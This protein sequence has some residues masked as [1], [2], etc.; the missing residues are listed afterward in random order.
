MP[1]RK[2]IKGKTPAVPQS[3]AL[4]QGP[5]EPIRSTPPAV[6]TGAAT[7]KD[8]DLQGQ[9]NALSVQFNRLLNQ[10]SQE[11]HSSPTSSP[12]IHEDL[13]DPLPISLT[14]LPSIP[15]IT[16]LQGREN[17]NIWVDEIQTTAEIYGIWDIIESAKPVA[18]TKQQQAFARSLLFTN[19][20][21]SIQSSLT[22]HRTAAAIWQHLD[23]QYNRLNIAQLVQHVQDLISIDYNSFDSIESFQQ[24]A[25]TLFQQIKEYSGSPN[26]GYTFYT[27]LLLLAIHRS[28]PSAKA[29]IED[30]INSA[31]LPPPD[32]PRYII[33]RLFSF[34]LP[35]RTEPSINQASRSPSCPVCEKSHGS[36]CFVLHPMKAPES[37]R[38]YYQRRHDNFIAGL[39]K[40]KVE[41]ASAD[42]AV[43]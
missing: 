1:A 22:A 19:T 12:S 20:I 2:D 25:D 4:D 29:M 17:Y 16:K 42:P 38:A 10:L 6:D 8:Q 37:S 31:Q 13:L 28:N 26:T 21:P 39:G 18:S 3:T 34:T 32:T 11:P 36:M 43:G 41:L 15:T 23:E 30:N 35:K 7:P 27:A 5:S 40:D 33:Q 14:K 9:I 24:R